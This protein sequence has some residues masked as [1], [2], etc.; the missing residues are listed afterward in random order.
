[1]NDSIVDKIDLKLLAILKRN[2]RLSF[3]DLGR[4]INLSPSATRRRLK[5][6]EN[7]GL[8]KN[9]TIALD[10]KLLGYDVEAF[11]LV[12]IFYGKLKRFSRDN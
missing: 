9:Y 11:F 7:I 12:K 6:I 10:Y 2:S 4:A 1:M 5:K 8:I 3:A